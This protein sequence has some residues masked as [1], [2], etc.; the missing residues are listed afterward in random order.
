MRVRKTLVWIIV[1]QMGKIKSVNKNET[2]RIGSRLA[3]HQ[4]WDVQ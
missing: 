1:Q 2:L 4:Q 3:G